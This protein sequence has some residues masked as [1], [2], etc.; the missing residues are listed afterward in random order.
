MKKIAV[1]GTGIM[2]NGIAENYLKHGYPIFLWNRH[3]EKLSGLMQKGG[4]AADSPKDTVRQADV[5]FEVTASD[6]SSKAVWLGENGILAG[7][8]TDKILIASGTFTVKWIG[9]LAALC[10]EK[11]LNFFDIPLT[12]SRA[13]AENGKLVLLAGGDRQKLE[14]LKPDLAA[15]SDKIYYF[16]KAGSGIRFKL[17][18]NML[19]A[20]HIT[21]FAEVLN[22]AKTLGLDLKQVGDVLSERPGGMATAL[23]WKNY[24]TPPNPINFSTEWMLKDLNYAKQMADGL[25]TPFLDDAIKK[26]DEAIQ[27]GLAESDH[28][29]ITKL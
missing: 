17:L 2:G 3:P 8:T 9:E 25:A 29:L 16:G 26:Y 7:A 23:A 6:E 10:A 5:V 27:K 11:K 18:L 12:G 15:I 20:I 4:L 13:G 19:H 1:I 22:I 28:T 21:A 14:E 24:Q